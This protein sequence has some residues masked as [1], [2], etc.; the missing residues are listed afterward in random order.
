VTR[1]E[2]VQ[3]VRAATPL[4]TLIV[5]CNGM[6]GRELHSAGDRPP[7]FYMIG[8]MGLASSIGLGLALSRPARAVVV[9]D[10]DGNVLMNMGTL[11]SIGVAAP[12]NFHHI[13]LDNGM[14]AS[15]GGQRTISDRVRLEQIALAAGYRAVRRVSERADLESA[16]PSVLAQAGPSML[17]VEV[18]PGNVKGIGRVSL[19]PPAIA[20]RFREAA[21]R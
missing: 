1:A 19:D 6:L 21:L 3:I 18:A 4:E 2:A 13:V 11:A 9:L 7:H 12:S 17:L 10:G 15:T 16:I 5:A 8:S 14:Y 20:R